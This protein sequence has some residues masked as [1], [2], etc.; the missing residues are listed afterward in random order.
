LLSRLFR[1]IASS[2]VPGGGYLL[3]H[4]SPATALALYWFENLIGGFAMAIRISEHQRLTGDKE[5]RHP[6]LGFTMTT[7]SGG[8]EKPVKFKSFFSEFLTGSTVFSAAHGVF[9]IVV[10]AAVVD[11]PDYA[12]LKEGAIAIAL[13]HAISLTLD[14]FTIQNWPFDKVKTQAQTLI[15]RVILVQFALIG[16][17]WWM[18]YRNSGA[19]FFSVFVWLKA[20]S[21]VGGLLS[22]MVG[23]TAPVVALDGA[24]ER[25]PKR[26]K[27]K[28]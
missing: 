13:C 6:Q 23:T 9:L 2:A 11:R 21:D 20:A 27:R 10:L 26:K 16:G 19:S 3:G 18:V 1:L 22:S 28:R 17:T 12:A 14:L 7:S 5:H 24:V 15:G 8:R 4:W 25:D